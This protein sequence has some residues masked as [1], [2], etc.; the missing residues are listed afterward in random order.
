MSGEGVVMPDGGEVLECARLLLSTH[1]LAGNVP[2][3]QQRSESDV[4][5]AVE[6]LLLEL[7]LMKREEIRREANYTDI[8]TADLVIE[9]KKRIGY[10]T[11]PRLGHVEQLDGYLEAA[12]RRGESVRM[13]ILTDGK[14]WYLRRPDGRELCDFPDTFTLHAP[15]GARDLEGWL[16]DSTQSIPRS[17]IAPTA[18]AIAAAFGSS[19]RAESV[20]GELLDLHEANRD[21][22]TVE[23]KRSLWYDLLAV[24]V[25]EAVEGDDSGLDELFVRHTYLTAVVSLA[26]QSAFGVSIAEAAEAVPE[27]L[28]DGRQFAAAVGV[29]GVLESDFFGW[30]IEVSSGDRWV[31]SL[32][33]WVAQFDW[34]AAGYDIGREMYQSVISAEERQRLG[35]YYTPAW[36]AESIVAEVVD[37]PLGQ[38]VL[39]PACGSGTFLTAAIA[40]HIES[41]QAV[42]R[43][44][45]ET[46]ETLSRQVIGIDVHPV[47]VHLARAAWVLA[48][49]DVIREA[50]AEAVEKLSVPVYLGDSLQLR[51]SEAAAVFDE[52]TVVIE[53]LPE[54]HGMEE[55]DIW[56]RFPRE[57]VAQGDAFDRLMADSAAAIERGSD[58]PEALAG[59]GVETG[60]QRDVL[61]ETLAT[62]KKLHDYGRNHIWAYYARNLV[63]P[64]WLSTDDGRVDRIVGNPPWIT[65]SRT[66]SALREALKR[67]SV[68]KYR[69]WA[70]AQY[71][72]HQDLAGL[73]YTRCV[74]LYLKP[75]GRCGMVMPHSALLSNH[76]RL[77]RTGNWGAANADLSCEPWDLEPV[78]PNDFF[79]V[80]ACVVF[81]TKTASGQEHGFA[82]HVQ[83]WAGPVGS[84]VIQREAIGSGEVSESK[85][86]ERARQGASIYP[87]VLFFVSATSAKAS[88]VSG[89]SR[90]S[91]MRSPQEDKRWKELDTSPLQ[92][93]VIEDNYLFP[94]HRGDTLVPFGLAEPLTAVLPIHTGGDT[95]PFATSGQNTQE[96]HSRHINVVSLGPLM[97]DRW[98]AINDLWEGN[99]REGTQLNLIG[100]LDYLHKLSR[101]LTRRYEHRLVYSKAGQPTAAT[102]TD[103]DAVVD[104]TLYW[105]GCSSLNETRYLAAIVN[106]DTLYEA[107]KPHMSKGQWGPRDLHKHLWKLPIPLYDSSNSLHTA[108][109]AASASAATHVATMLAATDPSDTTKKH[110]KRVRSWLNASDQGRQIEE[111]VAHLLSDSVLRH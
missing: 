66:R 47:A 43:Q 38:S 61:E 75:G 29:R 44:P 62:I 71:A 64:M 23:V 67:Q 16:S 84:I 33:R 17:M 42:G 55:A 79:P 60:P 41:S 2:V 108:L 74:E 15:E 82:N 100:Q 31:R 8:R 90:L 101:Q 81:A 14:Y 25:G 12:R 111:L 87:R 85:Y 57:L 95:L 88:L 104:G 24:A 83:R 4:R 19:A 91:P 93:E 106:S 20:L 46:L 107:V 72:P 65:Y 78:V 70:G 21:S 59:A 97:R 9:V 18:G 7:G 27:R 89:R 49:K 22:P 50:G 6:Y 37:E 94:V 48:A 54:Q 96:D 102:L 92:P 1:D 3:E 30:V 45:A 63:R 56:L 34:S 26:V 76:Y 80:P 13:G 5:A 86:R 36:L 77:W 110:R 32:A 35:E 11:D 39:D 73:F 109:A 58:L 51:S 52:D 98:Q 40:A 103:S 69:I 99:K 28:L 68:S 105:I 10:R 53:V